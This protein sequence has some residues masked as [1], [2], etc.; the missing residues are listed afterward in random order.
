MP[1]D[2]HI[3][4]TASDS[5]L[6]PEEV[7]SCAYRANLKTIAITDHDTIEGID[8]AVEEAKKV[9]LEVIPGVE[10]S[11]RINK[12]E[13]HFLGYYI[14]HRDPTLKEHL[15][16][17]KDARQKRG[18]L[19]TE[20]LNSIGVEID[21]EEVL[22]LSQGGALG[23]PHVARALL[24]AGK[25]FSIKEAFDKYIGYGGP[26]HVEKIRLT[27]GQAIKII[28]EAG[29][30]PVF[31]HPYYVEADDLIPELIKD[32]L[33][34]IEVYH[35]NHDAKVTKHYKKL[36]IKYGLLI[37]GGSDAHGSVKE[38]VTIGQITIPD[39]MAAK[40]RKVQDNS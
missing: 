17:F 5:T 8:R 33:A 4:T 20:K 31:A 29:G 22:R 25:V 30:I 2:L 10:L 1:A 3:H 14:N 35:P 28:K 7:V 38:G 26:A 39:E 37:T 19:I 13:A 32:G 40:L 9:G 24:E 18:L 11:S 23:R 12:N 27:P 21:Y 15:K 6:S 36:A 16:R 34:G